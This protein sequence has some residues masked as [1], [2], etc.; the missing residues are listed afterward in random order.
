M[1]FN[2]CPQVVE[3][4]VK[5]A[6]RKQAYFLPISNEGGGLEEHQKGIIE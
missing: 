3:C 1:E 6:L 5:K 2:V 4:L